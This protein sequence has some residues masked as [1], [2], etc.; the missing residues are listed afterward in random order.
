MYNEIIRDTD[1][2]RYYIWENSTFFLNL[3]Y[4]L[5]NKNIV[6]FLS[7]AE[8]LTQ[9]SSFIAFVAAFVGCANSIYEITISYT[10]M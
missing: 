4:T 8:T 7:V 1:A 5:K 6:G 2:L 9:R 3:H 10:M